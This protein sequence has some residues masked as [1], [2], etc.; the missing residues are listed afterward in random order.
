M[1]YIRP[2]EPSDSIEDITLL[3][4]RAYAHLGA[5]G[6]N[7]TAVDQSPE[8]TA[9]RIRRGTCY[10]ATEGSNFVGTIVAQPTH[11]ESECSYFTQPG[12]A[13]ANQLAVAPEFQNKGLGSELLLC[14]ENWALVNGFFRLAVDTAESAT[15]LVEFYERRDYYRVGWVQWSGKRYRS[16]V[17]SKTL[18]NLT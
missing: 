11:T 9:N 3:L 12:V 16:I 4:H 18:D 6:L 14:A 7:Y 17:L 5:M 15:R 13:C 10:V 8:V 1:P 2:F